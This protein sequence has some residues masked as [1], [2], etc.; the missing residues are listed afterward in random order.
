M[1]RLAQRAVLSIA[2]PLGL[3]G[4]SL[5]SESVGSVSDSVEKVLGSVS[6]S[7]GSISGSSS[8][9]GGGTA[10]NGERYR[11]DLCAFAET[12]LSEREQSGESEE[13]VRE[14]GR[15]A[16]SHGI[17]DWE[18]DENTARALREAVAKPGLGPDGVARLRRD[19]APLGE[20]WLDA[21]LAPPAAEQFKG[22]GGGEGAR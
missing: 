11:A 4:C 17:T 15:I 1:A 16:E 2:L 5:I 6:D 10:S 21:A 20:P 12:R 18:G 13:F 14:V 19:L 7:F 9:G 8:G 22:E 3:L